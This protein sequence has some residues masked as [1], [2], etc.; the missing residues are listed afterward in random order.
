MCQG[1]TKDGNPCKKK[2]EYCYYHPKIEN[3]ETVI[4]CLGKNKKCES[5]AIR[6]TMCQDCW[7]DLYDHTRNNYPKYVELVKSLFELIEKCPNHLFVKRGSHLISHWDFNKNTNVDIRT[8]AFRSEHQVNWKCSFLHETCESMYNKT[9]QKN[10]CKICYEKSRKVHEKEDVDNH[11]KT[12]RKDVKNYTK[13][14][15]EAEEYIVNLLTNLS[16]YKKVEKIGQL[17]GAADVQVTLQDDKIVYIQV[18][19]MSRRDKKSG[20]VYNIHFTRKYPEDLLIIAL[21]NDRTCFAST[22]WRDIN[23]QCLTLSFTAKRSQYKNIMFR[24]DR[25][26]EFIN[27]LIGQIPFSTIENAL[28]KN[29]QKEVECLARLE[30]FCKINNFTFERNLTNGNTVDCFINNHRIQVK[31]C[32][33]NQNRIDNVNYN[34]PLKKAAGTLDGKKISK[35]YD[36]DDFDFLIVEVGGIKSIKDGVSFDDPDFYKGNFFIISNVDLK[37]MGVLDS[38]GKLGKSG[39]SICPPDSPKPHWSKKYWNNITPLQ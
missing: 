32:S 14:G 10:D 26:A 2:G 34:I 29:C 35:S 8:I 31:Y 23:V 13:I 6:G 9:N 19:T 25:K 27:R 28:S 5:N 24:E 22:F 33:F 39:I 38:E 17:S 4:K 15:D 30:K 36:E 18:K 16:I 11:R 7:N 1:I 20:E 3:E 21:N 37:E 12:E